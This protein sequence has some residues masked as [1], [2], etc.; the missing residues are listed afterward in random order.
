MEIWQAVLVALPPTLM[1]LAAVITSLR[2]AFKIQEVH[3]Q[4]NSRMDELL[5]L[6][7][8]ASFAEGVKSETDK[9]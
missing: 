2:N 4:I 1:G 5:A 8:K 7:K 9:R 3:G 6:A